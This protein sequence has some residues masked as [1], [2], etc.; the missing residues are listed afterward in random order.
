[1]LGLDPPIAMQPLAIELGKHRVKQAPKSMHPDL[2]TKVEAEMD[3]L[4]N[5]GLHTRSTIPFWLA[6]IVPDKEKNG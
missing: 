4:V 6:N 3:M 5:V 2:A 1:M